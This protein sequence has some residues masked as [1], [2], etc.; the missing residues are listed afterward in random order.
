MGDPSFYTVPVKR[1]ITDDYVKDRMNNFNLAQATP[2]EEINPGEIDYD[3]S[4][5]T[6]HIS[7]VDPYGNA[8]AVT[9][10]LNDWFGSRVVVAGSGFFLNDEMDD[11]SMKPGSPNVY[12]LIGS[13]ANKIQPG[14]TMLSSM[15]PTI[16]E[17][18]GKLLM[19]VGSPGGPRIINAVFQVVVNVLE[20]KMGM[21][22]AVN[23]RRIHH[24]WL[25]DGIFAEEGAISQTDS[26][27]LI[28]M[29]HVIKPLTDLSKGL[30]SIG[31]TDCIL[32]LNTGQLEAGADQSRGD[33]SASG[34]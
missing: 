14:K 18:N 4:S 34:Y 3:E 25:P 11:F 2:S 10:T 1:L 21:Q 33:D 13:E 20:Y 19:V 23:A 7:V 24:Q 30:K 12:G 26:L 29:G 27:D 32:V 15:T 22:Q 6:T 8:V 31:R 17:E 9:T 28:N 16:I 5:E